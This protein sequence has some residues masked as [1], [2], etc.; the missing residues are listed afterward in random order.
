MDNIE[1]Y[2]N[3]I[4]AQKKYISMLEDLQELEKNE[5]FKRLILEGYFKTY[6]ADLV[7]LKASPTQANEERQNSINNAIIGVGEL[8]QYFSS[9]N[10]LAQ[11]AKNKISSLEEAIQEAYIDNEE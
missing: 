9:V 1:Y 5:A 11:T 3:E 6:A 2:R 10:Q 7:L 8:N 4:E